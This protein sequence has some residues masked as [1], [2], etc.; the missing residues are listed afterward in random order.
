MAVAPVAPVQ[1]CGHPGHQMILKLLLMWRLGCVKSSPVNITEHSHIQ[2]SPG[3][4]LHLS[5][6]LLP[7]LTV[8]KIPYIVRRWWATQPLLFLSSTGQVPPPMVN[9]KLVSRVHPEL[10]VVCWVLKVNWRDVDVLLLFPKNCTLS[11]LYLLRSSSEVS[12]VGQ[13]L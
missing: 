13:S 2:S 6:W 12:S 4:V 8:T 3:F 5:D 11:F 1:E 9:I 10:T 7:S